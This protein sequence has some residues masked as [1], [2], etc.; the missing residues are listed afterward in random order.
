MALY[1]VTISSAGSPDVVSLTDGSTFAT[2]A[3]SAGRGPKGDGFTGGSYE[4]STGVV[5][6]T[7]NDG[8]GFSTD[9][10]RG[11]D[12]TDGDGWTGV[13]YDTETGRFTFTSN[14]GLGYVSDDITVD[15]DA[16]VQAA[17]SAQQAAESAE[18][19][20]INLFD[21]FGDQYLGP[22]ASDP[23]VDN[24]G[25][26][27]TEGDI[28]FNTTDEVL[29]FYS[30]TAWVAPEVIAT[31]AASEA[32]TSANNA[33]TS[34]QNAATSEQNA[35]GSATD[36]QNA[37][38]AAEAAFDS[39]DDRY[40]GSKTTEPATDNDGDPLLEGAIYWNSTN[41]ALKIYDGTAWVDGAFD[42]Q[43]FMVG[44]NNLSDVD[45]V[46]ASRTNLG[47]GTA[48]VEDSAAFVQPTNNLSDL[49]SSPDARTNLDV[50][51][52]SET[53]SKA[54]ALAIIFGS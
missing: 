31:T 17:E 6:F 43:G 32:E 50:Y 27:L 44:S 9:D 18:Q 28:Y 16:A 35:A 48:A 26:P 51:S 12:G 34:E 5:T 21:Q 4:A 3:V 14:D 2:L 39:F 38:N 52:K 13:S 33:A 29:K 11:S 53:N 40:L 24:D 37:Q 1:T 10:L 20:T 41:S 19:N 30:G 36:A 45:D 54:V 7:S 15:L 46:A 42:A 47:L 25:D 8:L 23:T 22:K 49:S